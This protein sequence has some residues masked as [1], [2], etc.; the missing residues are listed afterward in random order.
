MTSPPCPT[1]DDDDNGDGSD[2]LFCSAMSARRLQPDY[3]A[4]LLMAMMMMM[5]LVC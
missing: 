3:H 1:F 2:G 4:I 5:V